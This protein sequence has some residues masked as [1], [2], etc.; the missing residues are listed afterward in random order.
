[1]EYDDECP[2]LLK[3]LSF[4]LKFIDASLLNSEIKIHVTH[5]LNTVSGKANERTGMFVLL[6]TMNNGIQ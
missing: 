4:K 3:P 6:F 5:K 1:M 2:C